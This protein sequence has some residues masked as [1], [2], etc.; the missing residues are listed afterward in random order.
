MA[1]T[2]QRT[3]EARLTATATHPVASAQRLPTKSSSPET[4]DSVSN[5]IPR[6]PAAT[7][8]THETVFSMGAAL[9]L[10]RAVSLRTIAYPRRLVR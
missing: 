2:D 10:R 3:F 6:Q 1:H 8:T 4:D 9:P 5:Q 7:I